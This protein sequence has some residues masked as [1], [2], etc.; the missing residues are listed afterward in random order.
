MLYLLQQD[1]YLCSLL[2]LLNIKCEIQP[3][4]AAAILFELWEDAEQNHFVKL[5]YKNNF[6]SQ[7]I[8]MEELHLDGMYL[9]L[10]SNSLS[11]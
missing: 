8:F 2:T 6:P 7:D 11:S 3:N 1:I 9:F 10:L 5:L 4:Y